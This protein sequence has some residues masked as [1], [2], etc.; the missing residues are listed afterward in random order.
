MENEMNG[1][2]AL[3]ENDLK[4]KRDGL[5]NKRDRADANASTEE[6]AQRTKEHKAVVRKLGRLAKRITGKRANHKRQTLLLTLLNLFKELDSEIENHQEQLTRYSEEYDQ[7]N[8]SQ[9]HKVKRIY[10]WCWF[11]PQ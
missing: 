10:L 6:L 7:L 2:R 5:L 8:V 1:L 11:P 4:R 3:L 9:K